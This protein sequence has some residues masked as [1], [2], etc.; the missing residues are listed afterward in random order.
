[1]TWNWQYDNWLNFT[2]ASDLLVPYEREFLLR[3]LMPQ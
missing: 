2:F 1:M 3:F